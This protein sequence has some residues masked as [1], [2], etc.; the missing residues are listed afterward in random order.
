MG[1]KI[2]TIKISLEIRNR[3]ENLRVYRRETYNEILQK[4]FEILN[5][6]RANPDHARMR[7]IMLD[8]ERKR[9]LG[10]KEKSYKKYNLLSTPIKQ[11]EKPDK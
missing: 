7:L 4:V 5:I 9:N 2:T 10:L 1:K 8:R 6:C 3:L 11:E